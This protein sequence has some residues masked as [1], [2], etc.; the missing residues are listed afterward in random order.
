MWRAFEWKSVCCHTEDERQHP[1]P[2]GSAMLLQ[3]GWLAD[4]VFQPGWATYT[5]YFNAAAKRLSG[6]DK[7]GRKSN[8]VII[9]PGWDNVRGTETCGCTVSGLLRWRD[10]THTPQLHH[11][12]AQV[13]SAKHSQS[14]QCCIIIDSQGT[15]QET[16][17]TDPL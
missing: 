8:P 11:A 17:L 12:V 3:G 13:T 4:G 14:S 6:C 15:S 10:Q 5:S 2:A 9:G 7:P 1:C 16:Y